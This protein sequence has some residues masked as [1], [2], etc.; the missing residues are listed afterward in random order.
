MPAPKEKKKLN[1]APAEKPVSRLKKM[2]KEG[3]ALEMPPL[4]APYLVQ[5]L[6]EVG[7]TMPD[8]MGSVPLSFSELQSWQAQIGIELQS[9][10]V[11]LLRR[12]SYDYLS[13]SQ[14]AEDPACPPPWAPDEMTEASREAVSR[15]VQNAMRAFIAARKV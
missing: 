9:W 1:G 10:E 11:R 12:L 3:R 13:A 5:Y 7:P 2:Q 14:E 15:K 4:L 8:S 6:Y